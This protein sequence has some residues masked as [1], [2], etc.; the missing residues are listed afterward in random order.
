MLRDDDGEI[1]YCTYKKYTETPTG[2]E[3]NGTGYDRLESFFT[4]L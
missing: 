4:D 2:C 1:D 3:F